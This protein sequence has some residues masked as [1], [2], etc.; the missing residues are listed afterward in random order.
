MKSSV[1]IVEDDASLR[2]LLAI[3]LAGEGLEVETAANGKEAL[4][5]RAAG[6]PNVVL[7]DM[8]MPVMDGWQFCQ[9][10]DRRGGPRPRIV[11]V[12]ASTD[13]AKRADEVQADGWLAKP[14]DRD[15]LIALIRRMT[16][17]TGR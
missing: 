10:L 15:A 2:E 6:R 13:P 11:V 9:E 16:D 17:G 1:L 7:L 14:F 12:T 8:T 3:I 5:R 4:G